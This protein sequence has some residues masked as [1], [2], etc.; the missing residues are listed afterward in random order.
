MTS[1]DGNGINFYQLLDL[2]DFEHDL[3]G[4]ADEDPAIAK[5]FTDAFKAQEARWSKLRNNPR[6]GAQAQQ[7]LD[8]LNRANRELPA[9]LASRDERARQYAEARARA[10]HDVTAIITMFAIKGYMTPDDLA[11]IA[12]QAKERYGYTV[13]QNVVRELIPSTMEIREQ[14]TRKGR[15]LAKP[16]SFTAFNKAE[17]ELAT[18]GYR[19]LYQMLDPGNMRPAAT[20]T[21][22]W[23]KK[24]T[25]DDPKNNAKQDA[26]TTALKNLYKM[27]I[28][29]VFKD[30][31]S[32]AAYDDYLAYTA[33]QRVLDEV[34]TVFQPSGVLP[35]DVADKY[36]DRILEGGTSHGAAITRDDAE[37][38]LI[39]W[40]RTHDIAYTPVQQEEAAAGPKAEPCPWCGMLLAPGT[41]TCAHCGGQ[42]EVACPQCHERNRADVRFC[43]NCGY[44]YT[45]LAKAT[46][47]CDEARGEAA[48]LR[49]DEAE[50]LLDQ[51]DGL[52]AGLQDVTRTK[53]DIANTR[54]LVGDLGTRLHAAI[55]AHELANAD[56]IYREIAGRS[57]GFADP[58]ARN[59]I[60][61][62]L[63]KARNAALLARSAPT[64]KTL[65]ELL[66][67]YDACRDLP[68]LNTALAAFTPRPV[69]AVQA[70]A[71]GA[72]R[73]IVVSWR[74]ASGPQPSYVL[75]R[76]RGSRPLT[77]R[78]GE[79][80]TETTATTYVDADVEPAV[81]Y[82]YAVAAKVGPTM[83]AAVPSPATTVLFEVDDLKVT[84]DESSVHMA[85][86]RPRGGVVEVWRR[87]DRAPVR[88]GD[89]VRVTN[90][91]DSG[92]DDRGLAND[93]PVHYTVFVGYRMPDGTP[94]YSSG[95]R[96][97]TTPSAP[98]EPIDFLMAQL[99]PGD[100]FSLEW[101]APEGGEARFYATR[102]RIPWRKGDMVP[103]REIA[104]KASPLPVT[105]RGDDTG[106]FRLAD[107]AIYHIVAVTAKNDMGVIGE[108]TTVSKRKAVEITRI[109][110]SGADAIV[111]FDWPKDCTRVLLAWRTDRFPA[112]AQEKGA[113][114]MGATKALY[115]MAQALVV[116]G[117]DPHATYYFSLFA[118]I[119]EGTSS[120]YSASSSRMFS[121]SG[122]PGVPLPARAATDRGGVPMPGMGAQ[123]VYQVTAHKGGFGF[124]RVSRAQLD[125]RTS[126]PLP[127]TELR[128]QQGA[129]PM[130][131][132][133]GVSIAQIPPIDAAGSH[134]FPLPAN[135]LAKGVFYR[136]FFTDE[137]AYET[138]SLT[139]APGV[140][141]RI[142]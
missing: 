71:D 76:K 22:V 79:T 25:A 132:T 48:S 134:S 36:V 74:P 51:A 15:E 109:Q 122:M 119:G 142:G 8:E 13:P 18:C 125:I 112:S 41:S 54:R 111:R 35:Q 40:C 120:S 104:S 141:P 44:A 124:G 21:A 114:T 102:G 129:L 98:A 115:D 26:R 93:V 97:T 12:G 10:E 33:M 7:R 37:D 82:C 72:G 14:E 24:A 121:F 4:R 45:N 99:M 78:D 17:S 91:I 116:R 80:L 52:W 46:A 89:G 59:A 2:F 64:P 137:H 63:A 81:D 67:A 20:S 113:T 106:T 75:V 103:L 47:L 139:V 110:A 135:L 11:T 123:A 73:R 55:D 68:E 86:G 101:D 88:P 69:A 94:A 29:R 6:E 58:E 3:V 38:H 1:N 53:S 105:P 16:K 126:G 107:D 42:V 27:C 19:D 127:A 84:P 39:W 32:R 90:V 87:P 95:V 140:M 96:V 133:Q 131:V 85:W 49:F 28:G 43:G 9:F 100:V 77:I 31:A 66:D 61:T 57:P 23:L 56:R 30:D 50:R 130:F 83:S 65:P 60:D 92:M 128:G 5:T 138:N 62:G 118:L 136:L 117:L 108:T 70:K 34:A